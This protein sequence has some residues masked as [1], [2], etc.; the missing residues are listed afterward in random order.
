MFSKSKI[1]FLFHKYFYKNFEHLCLP[2]N[3]TL[4]I[5]LTSMSIDLEKFSVYKI[6]L[7]RRIRFLRE[8]KGYSL[9]DIASLCNIEKTSISRIENGRTNITFKTAL[10]ICSALEIELSELFDISISNKS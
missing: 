5:I 8:S 10:T 9:N 1:F 7:G 3:I 2:A 4:G 6:I